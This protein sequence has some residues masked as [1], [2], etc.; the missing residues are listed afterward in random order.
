MRGAAEP[1]PPTPRLARRI[2]IVNADPATENSAMTILLAD[3]VDALNAYAR[4]DA[5][6]TDGLPGIIPEVK[7]ITW[8]RSDA[9]DP[10]LLSGFDTMV[11]GYHLHSDSLPS[12]LTDLLDALL[13]DGT[14]ASGTRLYAIASLESREPQRARISFDALSNSCLHAGLTWRGGLAVGDSGMVRAAVRSPRMGY[15]RRPVSEAID[16]LI[17]AVRCGTD[18]GVIEAR[19]PLPRLVCELVANTHRH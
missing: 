9:F 14:L 13:A 15:L 12:H 7:V 4:F 11:L 3:F 17:L 18:A 10:K 6:P 2:V 16:R 1:L 5:D 19:Q 8:N